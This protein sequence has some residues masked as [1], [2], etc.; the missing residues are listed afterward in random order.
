LKSETN[1]FY[2]LLFELSNEY[3]HGILLLLQ[4]RPFRITDMAKELSL[5][6]PEI[7]RHVSRLQDIGLIQRDMNGFYRLTPYGDTALLILMEYQFLASNGEYFKTHS[8]S[9]IPTQFVKQIGE[10]YD[11]RK[12]DDA[13]NFLRHTES[14]FNES[15]DYVW[16]LVD[17]FPITSLSTI[18]KTIERGVQFRI[19]EPR[20]RILDPDLAALTSDEIQALIRARGTPLVEQRMLDEVKVLLCLSDN[21]FVLAF[22]TSDG[23]F[24]YKGF[25]ETNETALRWCRALFQHYWDEAEPRRPISPTVRTD[26]RQAFRR[27]KSL[28][29]VVIV[30]HD[31]SHV[32]AQ[33]V[34]DAVDNYDEVILR[35][36]FNFGPTVVQI[37]RSVA[38]RGEGREDDIP[39]TIVYKKGWR[40]PLR[41]FDSVFIIDC[42]DADVTIENIQFTDFNHS[43]IWGK[44]SKSLN[45][46]NNR[47]TLT[48]G[49]GRGTTYGAF[50][51]VV[52]GIFVENHEDEFFRGRVTVAGNYIDFARGGAWG[53]FLAR[54]GREEDSEYRPDLFNHEYYMSFGIAVH[55]ASSTVIIEDNTIRNA[56]A[57]GIATTDN[58][59]SADVRIRRNNIA[60]D[61]YGSYPWRAHEAGAGILA[62]SS[63]GF[64]SPGFNVEIEENT[65]RLDRLNH[66]GIRVLGPVMDREGA[67]KLRGGIIRNNRIMLKDGYE[68][69]HIRKCDDFEVAD[70]TISGEAY[71]G[72]RISGRKRSGEL[73]LSALNNLVEGN[74]MGG[75]RI[76]D[77]DEYSDNHAD[78][79]MFNVLEGG[80][81][82]AHV[83]LDKFSKNNTVKVKT[84]ETVIDEGE[85]N[86]IVYEEDGD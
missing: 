48:T 58:L 65:I 70:N 79:R 76:K 51:D 53:G 14:L 11:S 82:T 33:L 37:S 62:Q 77:P 81:T 3:R 63:W 49:Y 46:K 27:G 8:L 66:C 36:T 35:G 4:E 25:T 29:S 72:I 23:K 18:V 15:E 73:D 39:S 31:D 83:W 5:T 22:P 13:M 34:Q 68:G 85:E 75:L 57:R 64:P 17:Q 80:S 6:Y 56:N 12:I 78:G 40:F 86:K 50:G 20:E 84:D 52:I 32:D 19:I 24:D 2:D 47:V 42:E 67:D 16:M 26:L 1:P 60:S 28:G 44:Q 71:Y 41:E 54:G 7:R 38:I 21:T 30:G 45:I 61:V 59:P 10:L 74:D 55:R 9:N 43:C 69:I